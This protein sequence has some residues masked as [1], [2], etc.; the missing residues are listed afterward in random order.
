MYIINLLLTQ[1]LI[2]NYL[3]IDERI[4]ENIFNVNYIYQIM[5]VDGI[6]Q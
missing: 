3:S 5:E 6:S 4:Y 2:I 1:L